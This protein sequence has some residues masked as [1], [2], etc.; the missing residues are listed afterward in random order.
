[1]RRVMIGVSWELPEGLL[2]ASWGP[3]W[4][5]RGHLGTSWGLL[6]GIFGRLAAFLAPSEAVWEPFLG[7][8][9]GLPGALQG[10]VEGHLGRF[11]G[12]L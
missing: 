12:L 8:H 4:A 9:R 1:M 5:A 3:P 6:W 7:Y 10:H 11:G 2:H